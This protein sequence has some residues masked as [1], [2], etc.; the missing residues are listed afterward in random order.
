M[1]VLEETIQKVS[2]GKTKT[3]PGET[4]FLLYDSYGFPLDLVEVICT[5]HSLQVDTT[6]FNALMEKQ[7]SQSGKEKA[8][9]KVLLE[10]LSQAIESKN[11]S[12]RFVGYET[13]HSQ[14]NL[15]GLFDSSGKPVKTLKAEGYAV[16]DRSPFYAESGGQIGDKGSVQS[17]SQMAHV[18]KTFKVAKQP[19]LHLIVKTG[20]LALNETYQLQVDP[21][22]RKFTMRNHTATHMLHAALRRILGDRV[23]QAGSLVEPERLRFDFTYPKG[24]TQEELHL[25]EREVNKQVFKNAEVSVVETSYE[26]A[27]R[28]G[29][30]AFFDEKYGNDVRVVRVGESNNPFSVE[31]CGGTHLSQVSEIGY[32]KIVSESSVASGVRR[33]EAVTSEKAF[34]YLAERESLFSNCENRLGVKSGAALEKID[35]L[36]SQVRT[37]QKENEQLKIKAAQ[38]AQSAGVAEIPHLEIKGIKVILQQVKEVDP[39]VLR[40]LV[41]Q[42]RD[43]SKEKAIVLVAGS[44]DDKVSLCVG[45]TKDIVGRFDAGKIVQFLASD[46]GGKGGGRA[47]FAQ[48]G[49]NQ[50]QGISEAFSKFKNWLE[51]QN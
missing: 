46:I 31:L 9:D 23:K 26:E 43:K 39:K 32:F 10:N 15:I 21:N 29:A 40:A 3:L 14:G 13:L 30:L 48:A 41:D 47:D 42:L 1:G 33:I 36:L 16:F 18:E 11:L 25:I 44:T 5:E 27:I 35:S 6:G 7:R 22:L 45:L 17:G 38:G 8:A 37:Y 19:V 50:P 2:K 20:E 4:A 28:S 34:E 24:V 51:S 49:G 12:C